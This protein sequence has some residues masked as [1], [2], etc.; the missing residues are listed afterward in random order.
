MRETERMRQENKITLKSQREKGIIKN[1]KKTKEWKKMKTSYW[2]DYWERN[3]TLDEHLSL[4]ENDEN[5]EDK[6]CEIGEKIEIKLRETLFK[7][8]S[9]DLK[10][11]DYMK[12]TSEVSWNDT[13]YKIWKNEIVINDKIK[14]KTN[15]EKLDENVS[16]I[17][18][19]KKTD[20][21]IIEKRDKCVI[22]HSD[23]SLDE[24]PN[25]DKSVVSHSDKNLDEF[26]SN[27]EVVI[28]IDNSNIPPTDANFRAANLVQKVIKLLR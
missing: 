8:K 1:E 11:N 28:L 7:R 18:N 17:K 5:W 23:K 15:T 9:L 4:I 2:R 27:N 19:I 21:E 6:I 3:E 16:E 14:V 13:E 10:R 22:S 26:L 20:K 25:N 24:F 12:S